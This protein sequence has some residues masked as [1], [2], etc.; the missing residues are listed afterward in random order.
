M[1]IYAVIVIVIEFV[2]WVVL[3]GI[4]INQATLSVDPN[5]G[6]IS[7]SG[8]TGFFALLM[9]YALSFGIF[10]VLFAF[11]QA[12]IVRG[13]LLIANGRKIE[14]GEMFNFDNFGMVLVAAIIVALLSFVGVLACYVGTLVVYFFT[15]FYMFFVVDK[16]PG[17]WQS[18]VDSFNLVKNN[19]GQ[20]FLLLLLVAIA[21]V[22]G[23]ILCGIGLLVSIPV[24]FLA[25][26]YGFRTLQGEAVA[27]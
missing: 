25:L 13:G 10:T 27:A 6:A 12:A 7:T 19:A 18:I 21:N 11:L 16:K 5:T 8:G 14:L 3:G 15:A 1:L 20:V 24:T 9:L 17:A 23:A 2:I 22:V 4:F 26:T